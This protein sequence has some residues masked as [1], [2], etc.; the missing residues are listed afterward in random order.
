MHE[1]VLSIVTLYETKSFGGIEPLHCA[2]FSHWC[3][4]LLKLNR[5][6]R[7]ENPQDTPNG[8]LRFKEGRKLF[9]NPFQPYHAAAIRTQP[10]LRVAGGPAPEW[11]QRAVIFY[12][13]YLFFRQ[14]ER[15]APGPDHRNNARRLCLSL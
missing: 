3:L 6:Y 7:P 2:R 8:P 12:Y 13:R 11:G 1:H 10:G 5:M 14:L 9:P 15:R 4:L